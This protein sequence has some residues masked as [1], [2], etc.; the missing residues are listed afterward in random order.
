MKPLEVVVCPL[1]VAE[2]GLPVSTTRIMNG[3][4]TPDGKVVRKA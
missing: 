4:I 2:D 1:V 3:E